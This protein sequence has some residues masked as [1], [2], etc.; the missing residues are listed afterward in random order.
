M[1]CW[2]SNGVICSH[3]G[4]TALDWLGCELLMPWGTSAC[5]RGR[6]HCPK[7]GAGGSVGTMLTAS[8]EKAGAAITQANI[9]PGAEETHPTRHLAGGCVRRTS[10]LVG[11]RTGSH[12]D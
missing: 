2:S 9:R 3:H 1:A 4:S 11:T 8:T 5:Q 10:D 6:D 12:L 7:A